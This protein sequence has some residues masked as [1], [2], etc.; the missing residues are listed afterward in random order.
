M[1]LDG[2]IDPGEF[3]RQIDD[4]IRTL[5]ATRP[6]PGTSGPILPGDPERE[7]ERVRQR[8]G[9]P[10]PG[11]VVQQLRGVAARTGVALE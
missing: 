8:D 9:V 4:V 2:F 7:A 3:K 10:L 5:R 11:V 1:R 6:A